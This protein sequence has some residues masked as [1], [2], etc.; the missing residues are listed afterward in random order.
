MSAHIQI[1]S[2]ERV[3]QVQQVLA[4]MEE[5][6]SE[7]AACMEVGI[8]RNT[9]RAAAM[10]ANVADQ[11]ARAMVA[12]AQCQVDAIEQTIEDMRDKKITAK[13]ANVEIRARQWFASKFLPRT[14]GEKLDI[15]SNSEHVA[16]KALTATERE[17]RAASIAAAAALRK[18][19]VDN[20]PFS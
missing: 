4:L 1:V 5:G 12:M 11:Y 16:G 15:T 14:Y 13:E 9:F 2:P 17:A 10:R 20:D 18:K 6:H 8:G 3:A 7:R 19:G